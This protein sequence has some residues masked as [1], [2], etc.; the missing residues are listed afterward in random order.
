MDKLQPNP[1][2]DLSDNAA[3]V[4]G[5]IE[6]LRSAFRQHKAAL[7]SEARD[8]M[9]WHIKSLQNAVEEFEM[10]AEDD[11]SYAKESADE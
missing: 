7:T 4:R 8:E 6:D 9:G 2:R 10:M 3:E 1:R 5:A 11:D